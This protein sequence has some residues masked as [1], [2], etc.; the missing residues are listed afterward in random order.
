MRPSNQRDGLPGFNPSIRLLIAED[1]VMGC[2]LLRDGLKRARIGL[3][4]I[5]LAATSSQILDL[6]SAHSID[7]A[8]ISEDLQ[9]GVQK[10]LETIDLLRGNHPSVRSVLLVRRIRPEVTLGAFRNGAKGVFSRKDSIRSLGRCIAAVQRGQVWVNSEQLEVLL[11]AL[12][13][14]KPLQLKNFEGACLLTKREDQVAALVAEGLTNPEVAKR[15]GL[16]EHTVGNYLFKMY[17]KLGISS[18]VEFVL[19]IR[20]RRQQN[21]VITSETRPAAI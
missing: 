2:Q 20:G 17:E 19:Y 7:V 3:R 4:E 6:C 9:D 5:H 11:Q 18:R 13:E 21:Q 15:L 10:G 16:S 14:S 12:I 1:T 8:L